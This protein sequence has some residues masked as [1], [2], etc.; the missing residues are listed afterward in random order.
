MA[1]SIEF[2]GCSWNHREREREGFVSEQSLVVRVKRCRSVSEEGAKKHA[3]QRW[4]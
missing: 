4:I 1:E 3:L 2:L